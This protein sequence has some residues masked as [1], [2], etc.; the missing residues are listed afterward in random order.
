MVRHLVLLLALAG[1]LL[2]SGCCHERWC[3]RPWCERRCEPA[4]SCPCPCE[5]GSSPGTLAPPVIVPHAP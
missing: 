5:C 1:T 2:T 4:C 3:R